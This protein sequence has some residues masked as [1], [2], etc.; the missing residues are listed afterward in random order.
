MVVD[1]FH[2]TACKRQH[3]HRVMRH[4]PE[5]SRTLYVFGAI[6]RKITQINGS[7]SYF[8]ADSTHGVPRQCHEVPIRLHRGNTFALPSN[9]IHTGGCVPFDQPKDTCRTIF[10]SGIST[11]DVTYRFMCGVAT[12]FWAKQSRDES[13]E[14]SV[15]S[16]D[17]CHAKN[18]VGAY[19][20]SG[21]RKLFAKHIGDLCRRCNAPSP[22]QPIPAASPPPT[23]PTL[24]PLRRPAT[25][26]AAARLLLP[27][28]C[29]NRCPQC[30]TSRPLRQHPNWRIANCETC[31]MPRS[32]F[33]PPRRLILSL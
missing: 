8:I 4:V 20:S 12:L 9:V 3:L 33:C 23:N 13:K 11:H 27:F 28:C 5:G 18:A 14:P 2:V 19:L 24:F 17:G 32:Y 16:I 26:L 22:E 30:P 6:E 1:Y 31:P 25:C 21:H 10:F 29:P 7:Q 15:G